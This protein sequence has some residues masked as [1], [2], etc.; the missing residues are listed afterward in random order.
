MAISFGPARLIILQGCGLDSA[1]RHGMT[2]SVQVH[3]TAELV[4]VQFIRY[5]ERL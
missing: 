5:D 3:L 2:Q 4:D 1:I